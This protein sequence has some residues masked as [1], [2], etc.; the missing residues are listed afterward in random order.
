MNAKL[1]YAY[2]ES[3]I[4]WDDTNKFLIKNQNEFT[5]FINNFF[6]ISNGIDID[7]KEKTYTQGQFRVTQDNAILMTKYIVI[8]KDNRYYVYKVLNKQLSMNYYEFYVSNEIFYNYFWL[9]NFNENT[10][11]LVQRKMKPYPNINL[12]KDDNYLIKDNL[13]ISDNFELIDSKTLNTSDPVVNE[14]SY[15]LIN[16]YAR[17]WFTGTID[18]KKEYYMY[19]I[20]LPP[21]ALKIEN[22][23]LYY[24]APVCSDDTIASDSRMTHNS[25]LKLYGSSFVNSIIITTTPI[26]MKKYIPSSTAGS[27]YELKF[28]SG[29][30]NHSIY[31]YNTDD[32]T[33]NNDVIYQIP[34]FTINPENKG[35]SNVLRK[36]NWLTDWYNFNWINT[37]INIMKHDQQIPFNPMYYFFTD[38]K[39][40]AKTTV[41][42]VSS[43]SEIFKLP[44]I[45]K[46]PSLEESWFYNKNI[47]PI[48][49]QSL[50]FTTNDL[51]KNFQATQYT[52]YKTAIM[53]S[54]IRQATG[55]VQG[56][57]NMLGGLALM[58]NPFTAMMGA[59]MTMGGSSQIANSIVNH[60]ITMNTLQASVYDLQN[61]PQTP[62]SLS[63]DGI[64]SQLT[65][66]NALNDHDIYQ[67]EQLPTATLYR[68][69]M[70]IYMHGC[71]HSN[72]VNFTSQNDFKI[73]KIFNYWKIVDLH[74]S[75]SLSSLNNVFL[76]TISDHF[77]NGIRLWNLDSNVEI[78]DYSYENWE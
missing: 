47:Y 21:S 33:I 48:T 77:E 64:I 71:S 73:F 65:S 78:G 16:R 2:D 43:K 39:Q 69:N 17:W 37:R 26:Y 13:L 8:F 22:K 56:G 31:V 50:V 62:K 5:T 7:F 30:N 3:K 19:A 32:Y 41:I 76:K 38:F 12:I 6:D 27:F 70:T 10:P 46:L 25:Y 45:Y 61:S 51:W 42:N 9:L 53:N 24:L 60:E 36:R 68:N 14:S 49:T 44:N 59:S 18:G 11:V 29:G 4:K 20:I 23:P 63:P 52:S 74:K 15:N 1:Y 54:E 28:S 35:G 67:L 58:S 55:S 75:I 57:A 66:G 40:Y 72:F 34:Q